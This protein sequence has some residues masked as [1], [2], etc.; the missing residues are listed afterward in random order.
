MRE[1]ITSKIIII[2]IYACLYTYVLRLKRQYWHGGPTGTERKRQS[3]A[4]NYAIYHLA[5]W[6]FGDIYGANDM[7]E[8]C[9]RYWPYK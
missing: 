4:D 9:P 7:R 2:Y 5:K 8:S 1:I 6:R 3:C